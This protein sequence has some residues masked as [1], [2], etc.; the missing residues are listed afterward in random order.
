MKV[1]VC[2]KFYYPVGGPETIVHDTVRELNAMGHTAIPFAMVHPSNWESDYAPYFVPNVDYTTKHGKSIGRLLK[3]GFD[4]VYSREAR[5]CIERLIADTKPDIAHAHNIYHQLSPSILLAL[6]KAGIPTA[7][8]LHD[9]KLVCANMLFYTKGKV[10]ERCAG[11]K[12]YHAVLNKC[13]K[14]SYV[15]SA[16]CCLE[17][18]LHRLTRVYEKTVNLFITPSQFLKDR[19]VKSGRL[20]EKTVEVLYNYAETK[21]IKPNFTPGNYALFMGKVETFKGVPTLLKAALELP[22]IEIRIAGRG[23]YLEQGKRFAEENGLGNA[24]FLGFQT[25]SDLER[26]RQEARFVVVPSEWYENCP[27]V[28]LEAFSAGKPVIGA[29]IGGIPELVEHGVNGLLYE[30]GDA[31]GLAE[32]MRKLSKDDDLVYEMGRKARIKAEE[33]Y[34]LETYMQSLLDI[35]Q[36]LLP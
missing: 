14:D 7:L 31:E 4:I 25:G 9:G 21:N 34:S 17:E 27:M 33:K 20:P 10:C 19:M 11:K 13:V 2:N 8:T 28:V 24:H 18:T 16:L 29:R 36:R 6:K 32:C 15:S 35:Y 3:E 30:P 22:D 23:T 26:L 1:L 12:F 5:R